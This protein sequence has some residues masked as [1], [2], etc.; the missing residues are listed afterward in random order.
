[1][2]PMLA[3][4]GEVARQ[5]ATGRATVPVLSTVTGG[6][7]ATLDADYWVRHVSAPVRFAEAADRYWRWWNALRRRPDVLLIHQAALAR[8][9]AARIEEADP[10]GAPLTILTGHTHHQRVDLIGPVSVP[11]AGSGPPE[12][13]TARRRAVPRSCM[14]D[15]ISWPT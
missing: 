2:E 1:M 4:F 15:T 14:R 6:E 10:A 7:P 13:I 3:D 5:A 12:T 8:D 11:G 9:L